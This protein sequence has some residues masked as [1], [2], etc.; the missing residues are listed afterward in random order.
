MVIW[1][2]CQ[3]DKMKSQQR[4]EAKWYVAVAPVL[5][6]TEIVQAEARAAVAEGRKMAFFPIPAVPGIDLPASYVDLRLIWP[7]R[8][9]MLTDRITAISA[10]SK[11]ALYMH[12]FRFLTAREFAL[13]ATC[14]NCAAALSM[15]SFLPD[16]R[17]V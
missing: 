14:P 12:L 11:A 3:I 6:L 4:D 17:E 5:P 7:M 2:D 1:E 10:E 13:E 8:Q 16:V 9:A 15:A